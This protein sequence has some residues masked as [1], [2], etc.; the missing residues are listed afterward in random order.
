MVY[1][2]FPNLDNEGGLTSL[3]VF[4][5]AGGLTIELANNYGYH[6]FTLKETGEVRY[7]QAPL[8]DNDVFYT[9]AYDNFPSE[10]E[11]I[12]HIKRKRLPR[13]KH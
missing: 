13:A 10:K 11:I 7:Y 3:C 6:S 5:A 1:E 12:K 2:A 4:P 8:G 9:Q